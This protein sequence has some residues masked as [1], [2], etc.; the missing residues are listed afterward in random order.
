M[1]QELSHYV[2]RRGIHY[3]LSP[4]QEKLGRLGHPE[5]QMPNIIHIAG[6]N[7]KGSTLTFLSAALQALGFRVG[8]FT[9][10]HLLSYTE[11]FRI[12]DTPITEAKFC[13]LF[14]SV[15]HQL[16]D[17]MPETTEFEILT[18]MAFD[19]FKTEAPDFVI[20][21]TGLG[22][23]L[24]TTNAATPILSIITDIGLDHQS[25]LGADLQAIAKEKAGIIKPNTPVV[26]TVQDPTVARLIAETAKINHAPLTLAPES[27]VAPAKGHPIPFQNRNLALGQA[28]LSVLAENQIIPRVTASC[29]EAMADTHFWGRFTEIKTPNQHI[30]IDAAHNPMGVDRLIQSL[31]DRFQSQRMG[32][33][34]G[35]LKQKEMAPML[36]R[37]STLA[38]E[39]YYCDFDPPH[40][41][42]LDAVRETL[43]HQDIRGWCFDDDL[44]QSPLL[45]ITGS[46]YFLG[47]IKARFFST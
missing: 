3:D 35:V 13:A 30:I 6:T 41:Y 11:R 39:L 29:L 15:S 40:S 22:G 8:T 23:R 44:P 4:F 9:S 10:P 24:D 27:P 34:T 7:G 43:P 31:Q 47:K 21:E 45:V 20:L 5:K 2:Y 36:S 28:A 46:I 14:K 37:L 19:F 32:F 17:A 12:N 38:S 42:P 18:L 1:T 26:T 16:E 25:I 33:L